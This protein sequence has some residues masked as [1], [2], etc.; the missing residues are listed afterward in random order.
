MIR[1]SDNAVLLSNDHTTDSR[2]TKV[3]NQ[4]QTFTAPAQT[5]STLSVKVKA[6]DGSDS[7]TSAAFNIYPLIDDEFANGDISAPSA[8]EV[9]S[10][11]TL[12]VSG[13]TDNL[14]GFIW[15]LVS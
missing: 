2:V 12:S 5:T 4:N 7:D 8:V 11:A 9:N 13:V 6:F 15:R 1:A 10:N 3:T 14:V